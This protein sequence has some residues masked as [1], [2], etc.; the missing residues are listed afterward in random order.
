MLGSIAFDLQAVI[1]AA[2]APRA[3]RFIYATKTLRNFTENMAAS[4]DGAT[5]R[6]LNLVPEDLIHPMD[7]VHIDHWFEHPG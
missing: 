4:L 1:E 7:T 3:T 5:G 2:G 6:D